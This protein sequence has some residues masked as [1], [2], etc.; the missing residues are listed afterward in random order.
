MTIAYNTTKRYIYIYIVVLTVWYTVS[1]AMIYDELV[2]V[3]LFPH[4]MSFAVIQ[5]STNRSWKKFCFISGVHRICT[6]KNHMI[7]SIVHLCFRLL[8]LIC[9]FSK[10]PAA[11]G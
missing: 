9:G 4:L 8:Q 11:R 10:V 2:F 3:Y 6:M 1:Y 7:C 5:S